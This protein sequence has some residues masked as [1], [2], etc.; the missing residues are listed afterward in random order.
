[1]HSD[2]ASGIFDKKSFAYDASKAA[3]NAFTVYLAQAQHATPIKVNS[4]HPG[5]VKTQLE[6]AECLRNTRVSLR[7]GP[8]E[9]DVPERVEMLKA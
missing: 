3:L 5:W 6:R 1:M 7:F 8:P 4:A 9:D 2:P